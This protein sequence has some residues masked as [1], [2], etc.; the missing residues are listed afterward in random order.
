MQA[1]PSIP[2]ILGGFIECI[3]LSNMY[4]YLSYFRYLYLKDILTIRL[5][6]LSASQFYVYT[7]SW[8]NDPK[9]MRALA[10]SIV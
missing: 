5:F 3:G 10:V 8:H 6:G 4:A 9:W 1:L 2:S 7:Q